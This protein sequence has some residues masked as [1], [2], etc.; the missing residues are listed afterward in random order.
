QIRRTRPEKKLEPPHW[1]RGGLRK[2]E[3]VER[4]WCGREGLDT[5]TYQGYILKKKVWICCGALEVL[6]FAVVVL[7]RRERELN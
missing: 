4:R 6:G 3:G 1:N 7:E 2:K 5:T